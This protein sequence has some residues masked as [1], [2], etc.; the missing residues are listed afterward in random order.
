M[1]IEEI[2][3]NNYR[4][5]YGE[6]VIKVS[7]DPTKNVTIITGVNGAGKTSILGSLSWCLYG[8][9]LENLG[10]L[11]NKKA[12]T[13]TQIN[14]IVKTSVQM[15]FVHLG[16]RYSATRSLEARR[17]SEIEWERDREPRLT[18][19]K[20]R[21]DGE[22]KS[23]ENP[24][25]VIESILP[26]GVSQ[27]FFFDGEKIDL[28]TRSGH[29]DEVK[30]AV[31]KVLKI[32]VLERARTH[33]SA[34]AKEYQQELKKI[35]SGELQ[36]LLD[37]QENIKEQLT[38]NRDDLDVQ[39]KEQV[40]AGTQLKEI[41]RKLVEIEASRKWS[42][43][44]ER[45]NSVL[46]IR[47]QDRDRAWLN[48]KEICNSG[49]IPLAMKALESAVVILDEK[50]ERGEIPPGI[51]EQFVEDLLSRGLCICGRPIRKE[52]DEHTRLMEL[53]KTSVSSDLENNVI[54]T[55][56]DLRS[57]TSSCSEVGNRLKKAI[58][59]KSGIDSEIE[60]LTEEM[61]EISRHLQNFDQESVVRLEQK[62]EE[63][64]SQLV[65]I[66]GKIG[67]LEEKIEQLRSELEKTETEISKA[68]FHEKKAKNLQKRFLLASK[69]ADALDKICDVFA[70]DMRS[71][72]RTEAMKI[73]KELIWKDSQFNEVRISDDYGLEVFDRWGLPARKELS[74]GER[75]VL[76]LAFITG[77]SKVTG[78]EAPLVMDT[79][80]GR[81]S[82][83][84]RSN[85]TKS[86]PE[87]SK[88]LILLVTDEE[89]NSQSRTNL[90]KK[91]GA[92]YEIVFDQ[93][94]G[95]S[96]VKKI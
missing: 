16:E 68:E 50:R 80:F 15:I 91:I 79:P 63:Y 38:K 69:V 52:G 93:K 94:S 81:L 24:T 25:G 54:K 13:E 70:A 1:K 77:M 66:A 71:Q 4:Q 22:F 92:N 78:E 90:E 6:Q 47:E 86:V 51:R 9:G 60:S 32:E 44:R 65:S 29:E 53:L 8:K 18:L 23:L 49:F 46:K 11:V 19:T 35:V 55:S 89:L 10:E 39:K 88:Q 72:I 84:H 12:L 96:S 20:V 87:I 74:A 85:I 3:L 21:F 64:R 27:Y 30:S 33:L 76:S 61:D 34:V 59:I 37:K 2:R 26:S 82:G 42:E 36:E 73:F 95:C 45:V 58:G 48:I 28:F 57:V 7:I 31:R 5:F 83:I 67:H 41:D 43:Q 14:S 75:Q 56:G 17:I 40:T 62:R